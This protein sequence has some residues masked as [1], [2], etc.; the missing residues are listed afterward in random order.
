MRI[1]A[2][3]T[4]RNFW[5]IYPES[6]QPLRDWYII[7]KQQEWSTPN[8]IKNI[9]GNASILGN[10]RVIFNIKGNDFRLITEVDYEI[11]FVFI[12]WIGTHVEYD[13]IDAKKITYEP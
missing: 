9:F 3:S 10:N 1:I 7:T 5:K 6:E 13:K 8:E 11:K 12:L 4:L 2:K